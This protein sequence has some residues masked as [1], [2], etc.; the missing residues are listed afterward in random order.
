MHSAVYGVASWIKLAK[1]HQN[2]RGGKLRSD[3]Q[4]THGPIF[5]LALT[6]PQFRKCIVPI[7]SFSANAGGGGSFLSVLQNNHWDEI[8]PFPP[9][10]SYLLT[11]FISRPE[12]H[13]KFTGVKKVIHTK[14]AAN[15]ASCQAQECWPDRS[16]H[17]SSFS[18]FLNSF[19]S[20]GWQ[21]ELIVNTFRALNDWRQWRLFRYACCMEQSPET[22]GSNAGRKKEP[23]FHKVSMKTETLLYSSLY[24]VNPQSRSM[25]P[26][27][28]TSAI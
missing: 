26:V 11:L 9:S 16:D 23:R 5:C 13:T 25:C 7:A 24:L 21:W 27:V 12:S 14:S 3:N 6:P 28:H 19:R 18:A 22:E 4:E 20:P 2:M 1:I 15:P 8:R 17:F 10:V